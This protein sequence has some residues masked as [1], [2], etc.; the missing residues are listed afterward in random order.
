MA[1]LVVGLAS[2]LGLTYLGNKILSS[3][4]TPSTTNENPEYTD[5][6]NRLGYNGG[7]RR[8][9]RKNKTKYRNKLF[10]RHK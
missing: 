9:K 6:I 10:I 8:Y 2:V 1:S 4:E 7:S 5:I 3:D